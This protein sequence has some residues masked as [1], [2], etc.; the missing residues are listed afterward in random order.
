M[1]APLTEGD[2]MPVVIVSPELLPAPPA[3]AVEPQLPQ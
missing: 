2:T 1:D 3:H